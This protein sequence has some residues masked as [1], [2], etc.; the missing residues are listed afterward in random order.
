M[1]G[2]F[3]EASAAISAAGE[4][5]AGRYGKLARAMAD[6]YGQA[7]TD[8]SHAAASVDRAEV[9]GGQVVDGVAQ[10]D[11]RVAQ[12]IPAPGNPIPSED[13]R[14]TVAMPKQRIKPD[15]RLSGLDATGTEVRFRPEQVGSRELKDARGNVIGVTYADGDRA[16]LARQWTRA[17]FRR[18]D[19][20]L[21]MEYRV[22][23]RGRWYHAD[24]WDT[25][26]RRPGAKPPLYVHA[27]SDP[28]TFDV[29]ISKGVGPWRKR[30]TVQVDGTTFGRIL[31]QDKHFQAAVAETDERS[32]VLLAGSSAYPGGSAARTAAAY[33]HGEAGVSADVYAPTARIWLTV[34]E[35]MS[36]SELKA[37]LM[38]DPEDEYGETWL[39][40]PFEQY[41]APPATSAP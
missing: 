1:D 17:K 37:E 10:Q 39:G 19:R 3:S 18:G 14:T 16:E 36:S 21:D 35:R 29:T 32:I 38:T 20:L 25:M 26:W 24:T 40:N 2:E 12:G 31:A 33:L 15:D 27:D 13:L 34:D 23:G 7:G 6:R 9:A 22:R 41:S 4:A 5:M 11:L 30:S 8:L 28:D